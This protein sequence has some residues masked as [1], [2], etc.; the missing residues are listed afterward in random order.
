MDGYAVLSSDLARAGAEAPVRLR[1]AGESAA[2]AE[3][4]PKTVSGMTVRV[5]TGAPIPDGADAVVM[6]EDVV[7][8]GDEA[9]FSG[10][11]PGGKFIRRRGED[12][13]KG[14]LLL[15]AGVEL[16]P[17]QAAILASQGFV[18]VPVSRQPR[19]SVVSTGDELAPVGAEL[20][21]GQVRD[22]S[23]LCLSTAARQAGAVARDCGA[24][25]DDPD[26]I[27]R[28]FQR[29]L[30]GA[31]VLLVGGGVSVGDHDHTGRVLDSL[32][33]RREFWKVAVKPGK[34]L[35]FGTLGKT[36]VFGLPGN[37]VSSW[38]SFELFVR[39]AVSKMLGRAPAEAFP[40][41]GEALNAFPPC[42]DR[43]QLLFCRVRHA[44]PRAG[45]E[46]IDPQGSGT[47]ALGAQAEAAAFPP[48]EGRPV[49]VG[50]ILPFRRIR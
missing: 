43:R 16:G 28:V 42:K 19:V 20:R 44:G 30:E 7:R 8:E 25:S 9:V 14:A 27:A 49:A 38:A 13:R 47:L 35:L 40:E 48:G 50:D 5:F 6:Q 2:G 36:L 15:D 33:L 34:P 29:A 32:G 21:P 31:D 1:L 39:P 12:V 41:E 10:G 23:G 17:L 45:L 37:P 26:S 24:V 22:C 11:V 46:I 3:D 18:E 4:V